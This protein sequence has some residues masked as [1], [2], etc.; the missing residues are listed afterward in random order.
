MVLYNWNIFG[1]LCF[2]FFVELSRYC[3]QSN[4]G[5]NI[6]TNVPIVALVILHVFPAIAGSRWR[7]GRKG[8]F[9]RTKKIYFHGAV[10]ATTTK[11]QRTRWRKRA[12]EP[13]QAAAATKETKKT[14]IFM[15]H[16][17][18]S[19]RWKMTVQTTRIENSTKLRCSVE[20]HLACAPSVVVEQTCD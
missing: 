7:R 2:A 4:L 20:D 3:G 18:N 11:T 16:V 1:F 6:L 12:R 8:E 9:W 17:Q 15:L 10:R 5:S 14:L 13:S 19:A